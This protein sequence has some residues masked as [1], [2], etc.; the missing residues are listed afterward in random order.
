MLLLGEKKLT[1]NSIALFGFSSIQIVHFTFRLNW[2]LFDLKDK[3]NP[4]LDPRISVPLFVCPVCVTLSLPP[5]DSETG[6]T[7]DFWSNTYLIK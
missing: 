4:T 7:G 6:W 3:L 1:S 5:L 2:V